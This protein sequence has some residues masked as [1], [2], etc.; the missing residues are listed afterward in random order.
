[1]ILVE[2]SSL[3]LDDYLC[4]HDVHW[5]SLFPECISQPGWM[6]LDPGSS[7]SFDFHSKYKTI[8]VRDVLEPNMERNSLITSQWC[9]LLTGTRGII[10]ND[11]D[12][13][14]TAVQFAW[15]EKGTWHQTPWK[16]FRSKA[17]DVNLLPEVRNLPLRHPSFKVLKG[18]FLN[19]LL[20]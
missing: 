5:M 19:R 10:D 8:H 16:I 13:Q 20:G 14:G 6:R 18:L 15:C 3:G 11:D 1:M 9:K 17:N 2:P 4:S 7:I 12:P